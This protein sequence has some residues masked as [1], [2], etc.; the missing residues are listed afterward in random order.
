MYQV[1]LTLPVKQH[2][3]KSNLRTITAIQTEIAQ[4]YGGYSSRRISGGWIDDVSGK[5]ITDESILV[6]TFVKSISQVNEI[7]E[8]SQQWAVTLQQIELLVTVQRVTVEFVRGTREQAPE[9]A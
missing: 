2:N 7:R 8:K 5:L 3:G 9:V 4:Q 6:W 1:S